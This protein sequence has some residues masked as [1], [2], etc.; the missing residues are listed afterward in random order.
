LVSNPY[1]TTPLWARYYSDK[2][3]WSVTQALLNACDGQPLCDSCGSSTTRDLGE[4]DWT[5]KKYR[6]VSRPLTLNSDYCFGC[7][8]V[9][10]DRCETEDTAVGE[11][12][13]AAHRRLA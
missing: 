3:G 11:H 2:S 12:P 4:W 8:V 13:Q 5:T 10:C 6:V 1:A 7:G 9:V